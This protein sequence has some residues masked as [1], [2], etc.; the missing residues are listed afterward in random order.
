ML[1]ERIEL[2]K[3]QEVR[4][5]QMEIIIGDGLEIRVEYSQVLG[6]GERFHGVNQ[7]GHKV[8]NVVEEK[9]CNQGEKTYFPLPFFLVD[10]G[11]GFFIDTKEVIDFDFSD[12]IKVDFQGTMDAELI[13]F[14]G[15]Y[16]EIVRD[17]IEVTGEQKKG[18]KWILGP[19]I[20]AH[21]WNSQEIVEDVMVK[22]EE[23]D[24]PVTVMVLEQWSDE[25]TFYIF[26]GA[27]YPDKHALDYDDFDF[28]E[29]PWTDPKVMVQELHD[30]GIKLLLWQCPVVKAIP[31]DEPYNARHDKE[32]AYV[33]ENQLEVQGEDGP[34]RIPENNWFGGSMIPDF[35]NPS[36][37]DWWF[38][39]RQ[40]LLDIGIDGF[41]TDGGE[42][43]Y[44]IAS[45]HVGE[46]DKELK[47]NYSLEYVKAYG[48]FLGDDRV[49][50]S[51]AGYTGQQSHTLVWAGDQKSTFKELQAVYN[52]GINASLCG[53]INWGF[54][55]G[56]FSGELPSLELYLRA[57]QLALF[58]PI[59]Q[60][61]SEPVGGQFSVTDPTRVFN[62]ERT[63]WN[64]ADGDS[65][66][67]EEIVSLYRIRMNIL[68]YIYSEYLK[69]VQNKSTLMKHM[70]V[71]HQGDFDAEMY[72][73]GDLIVA[74][75]LQEGMTSKH[76][77]LPEGEYYEVFTGEKVSGA[78]EYTD[79]GMRDC[80]VYIEAG[81]AIVTQETEII[82]ESIGN[83]IKCEALHFKLYGETGSYDF[84][85]D[86]HGFVIV[87]KDK[88][89]EI[90]GETELD[91]S[92]EIVC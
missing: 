18:P 2:G 9:F 75:V 54:D 41:K 72:M 77:V 81:K 13:V 46:T 90:R 15:N 51:R 22:L 7:K 25:A 43:I 66:I 36:A 52:A 60:I 6:L 88:I 26:N 20:S 59:M 87:W 32:C 65:G 86:D 50:F 55:I 39:N 80:F 42:F 31:D 49:A 28:S 10:T 70:C 83:E 47:N 3:K 14:K 78:L 91:V 11:Y 76:I 44:D 24:I 45:N 79:I 8:S 74:P 69:A 57:T 5:D 37:N 82:P 56:G 62:N 34:Y 12:A 23:H 40:Y 58:T 38:G 67:L 53:Q 19:W 92:Y 30:Q 29:S 16:K 27:K 48:D 17:F 4:I 89:I 84:M 35:T 33:K 64:M 1:I 61:H 85:D 21:R 63:P 71:E 73:F 68:P